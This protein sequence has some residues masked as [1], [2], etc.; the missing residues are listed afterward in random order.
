MFNSKVQPKNN[1]GTSNKEQTY[2]Y[3]TMIFFSQ[4]GKATQE[5]TS[6]QIFRKKEIHTITDKV[7]KTR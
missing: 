1:H 4:Y 3:E 6:Q 2:T 5:N 7:T